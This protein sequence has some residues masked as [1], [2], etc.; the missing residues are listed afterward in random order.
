LPASTPDGIT[1]TIEISVTIAGDAAAEPQSLVELL[2]T[3]IRA[4]E[5]GFFGPGRVGLQG[6]LDTHDRTLAGRIECE[7]L[8]AA[9]VLALSRMLQRFSKVKG[10]IENVNLVHEGRPLV[11][12]PEVTVP[13]L[14]ESIPFAVEYPVDAWGDVRVEIEFRAPVA[15]SERDAI[16]AAF[17]VWD[18]LVEALGEEKHWGEEIQYESGQLSPRILDHATDGYFA[19]YDCLY[20]VVWMG[21]RLHRRLPIERLT[22]E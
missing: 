21:L 7:G 13:A 12:R 2:S 19:S 4:V 9:A 3:W 17:A 6:A 8:A 11:V 10:R 18:V 15:E 16:F 22:M 5:I 20:S 14:S 1:G